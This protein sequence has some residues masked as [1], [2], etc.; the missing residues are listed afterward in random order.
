MNSLF[1]PRRIAQQI[2]YENTFG[3][4]HGFEIRIDEQWKGWRHHATFPLL[5]LLYPVP[6]PPLPLQRVECNIDGH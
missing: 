3:I 6:P 5:D 4:L 1:F 2:G